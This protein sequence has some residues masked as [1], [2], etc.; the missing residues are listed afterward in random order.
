MGSW[1]LNLYPR[2]SDKDRS[3]ERYIG[4][5]LTTFG[6]LLGIIVIAAILVAASISGQVWLGIPNFITFFGMSLLVGAAGF[7][8]G[9][10][11]GFLFGVP[12]MRTS[13]GD[14]AAGRPGSAVVSNTNL[15]QLS[16]WLTK[17]LVGVTLVQIHKVNDALILFRDEVDRSLKSGDGSLVGGAGFACS[18]IL[19]GSSIAGFLA[20]YLKSKTDLM[21]AFRAPLDVVE[22]ALSQ[23]SQRLISAAAHGV[24]D[25][26]TIE[27]DACS[28][29]TS[30]KLVEFVPPDTDDPDLY[31]LLGL[32]HAV[33]KNFGP[34]SEA[35]AKAVQ[36]RRERGLP[37]DVSLIACA[38]RALALAGDT[39]AAKALNDTALPPTGDLTNDD[40]E[41]GLAEMFA[42]LY[43]GGGY[44]EAIAMGLRLAKDPGARKASRLWLYL[45]SAYGQRH[46][47]LIGASPQ[48]QDAI[49]KARQ[50]AL[51]AVQ[52]AL[53]LDRANNLE[54][55][56]KVWDPNAAKPAEE[57]DLESLYDDSE[58]RVLLGRR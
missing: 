18:L 12:R 34:A 10:I 38:T 9:G 52:E 27:P 54:D 48:D 8:G 57:N 19:I 25:R 5:F 30:A 22:S 50:G 51:E 32:A 46:A 35:L 36:I 20:A 24:L 23:V 3:R 56:R 37:V 53:R 28:K 31:Q 13:E 55:L 14:G 6:L 43:S 45:A 33:L 2:L 39:N 42:Q 15:E 44:D 58:F 17:I 4:W 47:A 7:A 11:L 29:E 49:A 41:H 40:V 1:F 26:P 16:D 21:Y